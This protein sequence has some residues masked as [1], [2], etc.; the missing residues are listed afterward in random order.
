MHQYVRQTQ[1]LVCRRPVLKHVRQLRHKGKDVCLSVPWCVDPAAACKRCL[2][3]CNTQNKPSILSASQH[4]KKTEPRP[5]GRAA[6]MECTPRG[7][8]SRE[9]HP[10]PLSAKPLRGAGGTCSTHHRPQLSHLV[11]FRCEVGEAFVAVGPDCNVLREW[12]YR[13]IPERPLECS[14]VMTS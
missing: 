5:P 12:S 1:C 14:V 13:C 2:E 6:R 3:I 11:Y 4:K 7:A 10:L 9:A 8:Y